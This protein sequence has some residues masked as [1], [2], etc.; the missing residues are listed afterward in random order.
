[1]QENDE[2]IIEVT[3]ADACGGDPSLVTNSTTN[4]NRSSSSKSYKDALK[5]G[6]LNGSFKTKMNVSKRGWSPHQ[7]AL[8]RR[9][10]L[11]RDQR[12]LHDSFGTLDISSSGDDSDDY[13]QKSLRHIDQ[14]LP[15]G[16]TNFRKGRRPQKNHNKNN[17]NHN[18]NKNNNTD[19]KK[20]NKNST[21]SRSDT[22]SAIDTR[23][24][25]RS[26]SASRN[27]RQSPTKP[28]VVAAGVVVTPVRNN[29]KV[30]SADLS[31]FR[32][33]TTATAAQ[34]ERQSQRER[35]RE[36][37]REPPPSRTTKGIHRVFAPKSS[38][39]KRRSKPKQESPTTASKST[40][41]A[42][43]KSPKKKSTTPT[44]IVTTKPRKPAKSKSSKS[45][46]SKSSSS[47]SSAS[48]AGSRTASGSGSGSDNDD[49]IPKEIKEKLSRILSDPDISL[50]EKVELQL[51]FMK[52]TPEL[53][54]LF[55][56]YKHRRDRQQ[57]LEFRATLEQ[58]KRE[59]IEAD[60]LAEQQ[61]EAAFQKALGQKIEA[62]REEKHRR[63]KEQRARERKVIR[64]ARHYKAETVA[65]TMTEIKEAALEAATVS[66]ERNKLHKKAREEEECKRIEEFRRLEGKGMT[67][68]QLALKEALLLQKD[69]KKNRKKSKTKKK[70][71]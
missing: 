15:I 42:R 52:G 12:T 32:A 47:K 27:R 68:A 43:S 6:F 54:E 61:K 63:K 14:S 57:F 9:K 71:P 1:M 49:E 65:K 60:A 26:R 55:L 41:V 23:S 36:R 24:T 70:R 59:K 28:L 39:P 56:R 46:T 37:E 58:Q 45:S 3:K 31:Y 10:K 7:A 69:P 22:R 11:E 40:A 18:K 17:N 16:T 34:Q 2:E 8:S 29:E 13:L 62:E 64:D 21:C 66:V 38:K 33:T 51:E 35:E 5:S 19:K 50:K 20:K 48:S 25:S 67:D 44:I 4:S 53:K 30:P